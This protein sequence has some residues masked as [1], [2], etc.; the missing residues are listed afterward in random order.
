MG[1]DDDIGRIKQALVQRLPELLRALGLHGRTSGGV[2]HPRN[3][4]R[5][6]RRPG[7]FVIWMRNGAWREYSPKA[8]GSGD[9]IDLIAYV[10]RRPKD[11]K[12]AL[13]W[14]REW[15]GWRDEPRRG[16]RRRDKPLPRKR[17]RWTL[18]ELRRH[19]QP[20]EEQEDAQELA[21]LRRRAH[22]WW[23]AAG[24]LKGSAAEAYLR[25]RGIDIYRLARVPGALRCHARLAHKGTGTAWPCMMALMQGPDGAPWG[26]HRTYLAADGRG[27]APV[28]PVKM[29]WPR[30]LKGAA[31]RLVRGGSGLPLAQAAQKEVAGVLCLTEG[32]E[33]GLTIALAQPEWR[34]WAVGSV[35]NFAHQRPPMAAVS[36]IVIAADNDGDNDAAAQ[37][38]SQ[39]VGALRRAGYAVSVVR[40]PAEFKDFNEMWQAG[41][42]PQVKQEEDWRWARAAC[43]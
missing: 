34:V 40:P 32:I 16:G 11:R 18:E 36:K 23:L 1:R 2:M 5:D 13:R 30:G 35:Q 41:G 31:I 33:D 4:V 15:L 38:V 6:D 26:V 21:R 17:R 39:A 25:C 42:R 9:V 14:A 19:G 8:A 22:A 20:A 12:F 37:V 28:E 29:M 24:P 3:P 43:R 27:K 7:S 10:H